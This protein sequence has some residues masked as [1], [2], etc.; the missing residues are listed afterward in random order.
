MREKDFGIWQELHLGST[1]GTTCSTP[2]TPCSPSA[3]SRATGCRS[4]PRIGRSGSILDLATVAVRAITV[5]LYP[6]N[7]AAEV[8]YLLGDSGATVHLA[9]DQ[10]QV[11]K[12]FA[13]ADRRRRR[14]STIVYLEPRGLA[15][16][17]DDRLISWDDFLEL[18]RQHR[19]AQP[20]RRRAADGRGDRPTTS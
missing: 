2:P 10:E 20:R 5:G 1:S 11:D 18:G 8:E 4:T 6:T 7:P 3:S 9:E 16:Y 17:D 13:V 19:A 15:A 12:V 14:C